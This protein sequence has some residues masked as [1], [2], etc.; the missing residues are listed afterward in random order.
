VRPFRYSPLPANVVFGFG[1]VAA[2]REEVERLG[3]KRALVVTTAEQSA[4]GDLAKTHLGP[5]F[6]GLFAQAT[7]HTP[8]EVSERALGYAREV[9]ADCVVGLGGGSTTG[10]AKALALRTDMPQ[11]VVPTT[12]AGSEATPILGETAGG[13]KT[14]QR[15]M[16]VL[17][18]TIIYDVD[19][20]MSLPK[21][22]SAVSGMNAIAHAVEGLYAKELDP[23]IALLAQDGIRA[24]VKALP[25][26]N[27]RPDDREARSDALYGAWACGAVLGAVGMALHHKLCHVLG[28]SFNLP[29]A[30]T[31]A[32][33]LPHVAAYNRR[34]APDALARV[35]AAL[36]AA[37]AAAGLYDLNRRLG[38]PLALKEIGMP[39]DGIDKA[40]A[41][42]VAS[43]YWNPG[44][45]EA[46]PLRRLLRNA[47]EG[48]APENF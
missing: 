22:L 35:A 37:D 11:V 13:Q 27:D 24:L 6:A 40:V 32:I 7:M 14:T 25:V 4:L 26:I 34:H 15:S 41:A 5:A 29:H 28:G 12:Y 45:V 3:C 2:L 44:P 19:L 43:P 48:Q 18:E 8:V 30:E 42:A 21:R 10:L 16:K 20:T 36:D 9:K 23:V 1:T 31:H 33:V 38:I 17:P 39:E 47:Y 46:E